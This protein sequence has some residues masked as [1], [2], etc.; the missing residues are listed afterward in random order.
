MMVSIPQKIQKRH[1][2][3]KVTAELLVRLWTGYECRQRA[4]PVLGR[5]KK[6]RQTVMKLDAEV[7]K[8][9]PNQSVTASLGAQTMN[10]RGAAD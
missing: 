8:R 6:T 4:F 7:A 9:V 10:L 1:S 5:C 2:A 3:V